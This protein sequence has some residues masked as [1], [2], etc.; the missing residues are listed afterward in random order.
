MLA[1]VRSGGE[2]HARSYATEFL[3][4]IAMR[5]DGA[6]LLSSSS[7]PKHSGTGE[8]PQHALNEVVGNLP[9][10]FLEH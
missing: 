3:F 4:D 7:E 5:A 1:H 8:T 2:A 6:A 9:A 10:L